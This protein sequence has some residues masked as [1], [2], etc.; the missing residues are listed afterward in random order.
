M[1]HT[2]LRR[3]RREIERRRRGHTRGV[4]SIDKYVTISIFVGGY[5]VCIIDSRTV[6]FRSSLGLARATQQHILGR[7][8]AMHQLLFDAV[9]YTIDPHFIIVGTAC[10]EEIG[11][12]IGTDNLKA[13]SKVGI[14]L[15]L[16]VD[17]PNSTQK[18]I[19]YF[20]TFHPILWIVCILTLLFGPL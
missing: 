15:R 5:C 1:A 3:I 2:S 12:A 14:A 16:A 6:S 4:T 19:T 18:Y 20:D 7:E 17:F 8:L 11:L 13:K 10:L 9:A